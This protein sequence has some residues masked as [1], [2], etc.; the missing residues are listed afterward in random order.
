M[1]N[2]WLIGVSVSA[3]DARSGAVGAGRL[4]FAARRTTVGIADEAPLDVHPIE[5]LAGVETAERTAETTLTH[6]GRG[7]HQVHAIRIG[8]QSVAERSGDDRRELAVA[9]LG[10]L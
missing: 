6:V 7:Q 9:E 1:F 10:P 4:D 3:P 5:S 8:R 2:K